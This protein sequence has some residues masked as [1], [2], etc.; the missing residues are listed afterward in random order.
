MHLHSFLASDGLELH[1]A[2]HTSSHKKCVIHVHGLGGNF[3]KDWYTEMM[4]DLYGAYGYDYFTF[5]NRGSDFV[6]RM[7]YP[8]EDRQRWQG[9]SYEIFEESICDIQGAVEYLKSLGYTSFILQGH[10]SGC[11]KI[12]FSITQAVVPEIE[13][14]IFL[15]PCDDIGLSLK[16]WGQEGLEKRNLQAEKAKD[17]LITDP[18]FFMGMPVSG[19]TFLSH[20][21]QGSPFDNFHYYDEKRSFSE[22][23]KNTLPSLVIF[24]SLDFVLDFESIQRVFSRFAN[25]RL[26]VIEGAGH[27]YDGFGQE[28][29][30][31]IQSFLE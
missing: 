19:N 21:R 11:Q 9:Y 7:K 1:G 8:A 28:L 30:T 24:G 22:L 16:E 13:K 6:K 23:E 27:K 26:H 20:F 5:N 29:K 3:Y 12:L 17:T 4:S 2:L 10:S 31:V 18:D 15:S 14:V 25:Y